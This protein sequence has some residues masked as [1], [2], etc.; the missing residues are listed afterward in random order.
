MGENLVSE[1][2]ELLHSHVNGN[3]KLESLYGYELWR[4]QKSR[5]LKN[6]YDPQRKFSFYALI[7]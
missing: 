7:S 2:S 6:K 1:S 5:A 4:L 3:E